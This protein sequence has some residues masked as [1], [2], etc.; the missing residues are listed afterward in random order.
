MDIIYIRI[1][2]KEEEQVNDLG[3][4][5]VPGNGVEEWGLVVY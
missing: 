5:G 3:M 4:E 2:I 1:S